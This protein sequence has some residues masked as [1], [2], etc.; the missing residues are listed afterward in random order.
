[1]TDTFQRSANAVGGS[2]GWARAAAVV[3]EHIRVWFGHAAQKAGKREFDVC[4]CG[5]AP[6]NLEKVFADAMGKFTPGSAQLRVF[7][8]GRPTAL[9]PAVQEQVYLIGRE[10]L[11]N[12]LRH[13]GAT[14]IEGEIEYL[15]SRLRVAVRDNGSGID[16]QMLDSGRNSHRG[17]VRM[18]ERA[19]SIG[20][21]L[22]IWSGKGEGT[23]VELSLSTTSPDWA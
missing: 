3:G 14:M 22:Q 1:M 13:S 8:I 6:T 7:V 11:V 12:A 23:E 19:K 17:F 2:V 21:Q 18:R 15:S 5:D 4:S 10:A 16:G 20:A 9:N